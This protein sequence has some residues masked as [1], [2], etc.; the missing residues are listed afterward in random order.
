M[1][2]NLVAALMQITDEEK[3]ILQQNKDVNKTLYTSQNQFIIESGKF[4]RGDQLIMVRKHTRFIHFPMHRHDY[5]EINY[6][7][8]GKLKQKVGND[9]ICLKEGEMLFLNQHISHEIEASANEDIIINFIIQPKFFDFIFSYLSTDNVIT[10]FLINSLYNNTQNGQYLYF[11]VAE[12][13]EIRQIIV[14]M[15]DEIMSPSL[16]SD[17]VIKLNMGLLMIELIK[18]ANKLKQNEDQPSD[19]FII[20]ET[21]KYVNE[22]YQNASLYALSESLRLPHYTLSKQIKKSTGYT[23]KELLQ[24]KRLNQAKHLLEDSNV[25]ILEVA[26]SVGYDN[27][28]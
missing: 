16:W 20:V 10:N 27:I 11:A 8:S 22:H 17:S 25:S 18:H 19:H 15:V 28:S 9:E 24:E 2:K 21:M 23:F 7:L 3:E 5:I 26:A 14:K 13:S 6:V 1:D 12:V 4:L